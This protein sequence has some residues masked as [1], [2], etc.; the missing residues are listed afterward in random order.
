MAEATSNPNQRLL[1]QVNS[2]AIWFHA[3]KTRPIWAK[4]LEQPQRVRTLEGD[5]EV[6]AGTFLCRGEAGDIWP[7][8]PKRLEAKYMATDEI[9]PDGWRKYLPHPDNTGVLAACIDNA[10]AVQATWG[11]L[12]GKPGDYL[13]KN[14]DDRDVAYPADVWIVDS[15]LF[16][17][18]YEHVTTPP[19]K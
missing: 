17:A 4:L 5:E 18:T 1:D 9:H 14:Y 13:V 2:A 11:E 3:K 8:A 7:Q 16:K 6:P 10:F 19:Q 12:K 15:A